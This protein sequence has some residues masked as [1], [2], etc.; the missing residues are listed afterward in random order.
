M[1]LFLS[2]ATAEPLMWLCGYWVVF[3]VLFEKCYKPVNV[4]DA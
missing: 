1:L 4:D 3:L 2:P